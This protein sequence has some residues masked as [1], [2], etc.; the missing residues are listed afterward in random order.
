MGLEEKAAMGLGE[1]AALSLGF[2][3]DMSL[4]EKAAR[5]IAL[6]VNI[7][8]AAL[9]VYELLYVVYQ[10]TYVSEH[11]AIFFGAVFTMAV[12]MHIEEM[13]RKG[14]ERSR[15]F[16]AVKLLLLSF[17]MVAALFAALYIRTHILRLEEEVGLLNQTDITV[18]LMSLAALCI[19]GWFIWGRI[20][21][22]FSLRCLLLLPFR[23]PSARFLGPP[24]LRDR[25]GYKLYGAP[26]RFWD[27]LADPA[28]GRR[29]LLRA[30]AQR[31]VV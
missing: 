7:E 23:A 22:F 6:I 8:A 24:G 14:P 31:G 26:S 16:F 10:V 20:L 1:K 25:L 3:A 28:Y 30:L 12:L 21:V 19:A 4:G 9:V 17:S 18:G 5:V 2:K 27:L 29:D 15:T 13:L 11:Y